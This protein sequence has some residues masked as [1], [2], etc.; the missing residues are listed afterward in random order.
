MVNLSD[1]QAAR[2]VI[3]PDVRRTPMLRANALRDRGFTGDLVLKLESLQVSGSFKAR[4]AINKLRSLTPDQLA[5]GIITA[6]GGNHGVAVAYAGYVAG[7]PTHVVLPRNVP[8]VKIDKLKRW[9]ASVVL[10]G[11]V[12]DDAQR[13]ALQIADQNGATYI[14]PF[15]DPLIIAGQ[16]T[17]GLEIID[18]APDVDT[19]VISIGGGGLIAGIGVALKALK[20]GIRVVGVEPTGAPTL[21]ASIEAGELVTLDT[22]TTKAGTLAPRRSAQINLDIIREVVD[23]IVLVSDDEMR[24]AA[25]WLW[26]ETGIG[27]ELSGAASMAALLEHKFSTRADEKICVLVCGAGADGVA[28]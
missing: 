13:L 10:E 28:S 17:I 9:G 12:F 5:R 14:H 24:E 26:F 1:I 20:P 8:P 22:I 6:S 16:G 21:K 23:E 11:D 4:G 15:A 7:V 18:D 3:A 2:D 19:V 27:A 25:H